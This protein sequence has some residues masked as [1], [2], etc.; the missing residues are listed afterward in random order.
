MI[1]SDREIHSVLKAGL[2]LIE[3]PPDPSFYSFTSLDL[4]LHGAAFDVESG[5]WRR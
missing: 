1:L 4:T 2:I 5:S 3:P